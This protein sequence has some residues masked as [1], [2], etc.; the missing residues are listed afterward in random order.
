VRCPLILFVSSIAI[1]GLGPSSQANPSHTDSAPSVSAHDLLQKVVDKEL[2][3]DKNDQSLWMYKSEMKKRGD[4][5]TKEVIETKQGDIA[6][7]LKINGQPLNE[8][9]EEKEKQRIQRL[10]SNLAD[11]RKAQRAKTQDGQKAEQMLALLPKALEVSY[12][13]RKGDLV[14][15]TFKPNPQFHPNSHEAEVFRAMAGDI[16]VN[17]K[18]DRLAEINGHL[19]RRVNFGGGVLGHL[20]QGGQ[21]HVKQTE[22]GPGHWEVAQTHIDMRGK[23]LFFKT[24]S[25]Q[26]NETRTNFQQVPDGFTLAQ[27]AQ[28]LQQGNPQAEARLAQPGATS[29]R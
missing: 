20:D 27:A 19:I 17:A 2:A 10:A 1:L 4:D 29:Q 11:Q 8:E 14:D 7:T 21:F 12:G 28:R 13:Q 16:W 5:S 3:A 6:R 25:V 9:Q 23:A 26:E 24:V 18:E 15:L 22:A